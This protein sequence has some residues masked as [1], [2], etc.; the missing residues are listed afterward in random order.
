MNE[1]N[2]VYGYGFKVYWLVIIVYL[3]VKKK[4]IVFEYG[5]LNL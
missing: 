4:M 3:W 2:I 5:M 1:L